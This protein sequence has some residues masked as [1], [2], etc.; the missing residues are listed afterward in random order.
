MKTPN[1]L[2]I[3][4]A[5]VLAIGG[6][7]AKCTPAEI[8]QAEQAVLSA[9]QIACVFASSLSSSTAIA[10]ACAID[11][12]LLPVLEQLIA[13]KAAAAK[14]GVTYH[15]PMKDAGVDSSK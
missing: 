2:M 12:A 15:D 1:S 5:L 7:G 9:S 6:I 4:T 8:H 13:V 14:A 11:K 10:D 3:V